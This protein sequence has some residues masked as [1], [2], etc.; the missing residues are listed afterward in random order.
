MC[1]GTAIRPKNEDPSSLC[2]DKQN[3]PKQATQEKQQILP[4]ILSPLGK[5]RLKLPLK[6]EARAGA[7][8]GVA[9]GGVEQWL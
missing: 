9:V 7:E 3:I 4:Q 8:T 1:T 5:T 6:E 2:S